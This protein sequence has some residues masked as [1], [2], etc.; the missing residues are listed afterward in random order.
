[1]HLNKTCES[2]ALY[3]GD[4]NNV[5]WACFWGVVMKPSR[6]YGLYKVDN[7]R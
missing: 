6:Y 2:G 1:M 4:V 5:Y 7:V 3:I